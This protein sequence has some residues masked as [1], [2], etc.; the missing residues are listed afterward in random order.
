HSKII[1]ATPQ[2]VENDLKNNR[3]NIS[4][5]SLVVFDEAH[6]SIGDYAYPYIAKVYLENAR[7]PRILGLTASPGGTKEK[8]KE[9]MKNL[10]IKSVEIR[11]EEDFDVAP[12]VKKKQI[13]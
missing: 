8:I 9:I 4:K 7:N 6:H 1:F 5:F 13:E 10:G 2:T 11:T 12:W 3:L